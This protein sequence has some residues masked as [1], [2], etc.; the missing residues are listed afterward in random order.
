MRGAPETSMEAENGRSQRL[1]AVGGD[2][3]LEVRNL[4][5][6][7]PSRTGI[8]K[9]RTDW[10]KAVDNVSLSI[11]RGETFGLVGE[12]GLREDDARPLHH[13]IGTTPVRPGHLRG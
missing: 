10:V 11:R 12:F 8:L 6:F 13:A 4:K 3:L 7:Y 1:Q 2:T 5:T 9:Q